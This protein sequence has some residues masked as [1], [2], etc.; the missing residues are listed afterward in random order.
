V[1]TPL[2]SAG[3]QEQPITG[4]KVLALAFID[5][6]LYVGGTFQEHA[7]RCKRDDESSLN[8]D[9]TQRWQFQ[10]LLETLGPVRTI[11]AAFPENM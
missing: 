2:E 10:P 4:G 8:H 11:V 1:A 5:N 7:V 9:A 6:L 3:D